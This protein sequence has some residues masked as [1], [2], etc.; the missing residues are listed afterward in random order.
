MRLH[1]AEFK[2]PQRIAAAQHS[3]FS[4]PVVKGKL[5]KLSQEH[6]LQGFSPAQPPSSLLHHN[7]VLLDFTQSASNNPPLSGTS[8]THTSLIW[9]CTLAILSPPSASLTPQACSPNKASP[10]ATDRLSGFR[11]GRLTLLKRSSTP[12]RPEYPNLQVGGPLHPQVFLRSPSSRP[13]GVGLRRRLQEASITGPQ[14]NQ[15]HYYRTAVVT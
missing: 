10:T 15:Y 3:T 2:I 5:E 12:R 9:I 7:T 8:C 1:C 11:F 14:S 6:I 13:K 4:A